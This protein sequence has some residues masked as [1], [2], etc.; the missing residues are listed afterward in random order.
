MTKIEYSNTRLLIADSGKQNRVEIR[1]ILFHE[2]FRD[3]TDTDDVNF[4]KE[5]VSEN[6]V[7]RHRITG[8]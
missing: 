2:G 7:D 3:I 5:L 4:V 1:N 8:Q 6:N